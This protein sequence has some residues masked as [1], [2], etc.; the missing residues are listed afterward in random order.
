MDEVSLRDH[1]RLPPYYSISFLSYFI[2]KFISRIEIWM[3]IVF[4]VIILM[5]LSKRML[6]YQPLPC[7]L[8]PSML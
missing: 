4:F 8:Q 7:L 2:N 5:F 6:D 1:V 3:H